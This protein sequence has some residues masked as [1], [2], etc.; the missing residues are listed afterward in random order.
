[1]DEQQG[2]SDHLSSSLTDLMTSLMVIFIL[3]LLV[4]VSHTASKDAALSQILLKELIKDM[5]PHGFNENTIHVDKSDPN[6]I[7]VIVPG[8]LMNFDNQKTVLKPEG[9]DFLK[10]YIPDFASV[11][12]DDRFRN[13]VESIVVEGHTDDTQWDGQSLRESQNRNIEL[14]QG[15]SMAVVREARA[16]LDGND[17][18]GKCFVDK[19]SAA[20]R[21]EQDLVLVN[22]VVSK[23]Q[24]RRVIF[25]IRVKARDE[26]NLSKE[27]KQ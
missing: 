9:Q 26:E 20:G 23:D 8:K 27:L 1:M 24:S 2:N 6:A 5:K 13:S 17:R 21:G 22:G 16:D 15:R 3:L 12:C 19:L 14:S 4:F 25:R 11:L 18:E 7:L 10:A